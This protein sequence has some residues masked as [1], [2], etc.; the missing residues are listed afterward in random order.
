MRVETN[1]G[2]F[3]KGAKKD[4]ERLQ[5]IEWLSL[6]SVA[7]RPKTQRELATQLGVEAA[8]LSDWKRLPDFWDQVKKRVDER[9]REYHPDVLAAIVA[10]AK[11]G[12]VAAQ[13]LYLE[14]VQG[15]SEST[16]H[17]VKTGPA[18]SIDFSRVSAEE[19][20]QLNTQVAAGD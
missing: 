18:I 11:K 3:P 7:R 10:A 20:Q 9:V 17:E 12:N 8:T 15:W 16:R 5:F 14:Y 19:L 6:P 13:K 4:A 1:S 2:Q